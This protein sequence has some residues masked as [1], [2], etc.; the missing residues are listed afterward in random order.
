MYAARM[1]S[2]V[3]ENEGTPEEKFGHKDP[4]SIY[5]TVFS[6]SSIRTK[7]YKF[8]HNKYQHILVPRDY[9]LVH[10]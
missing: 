5:Y 6:Y 1:K 8:K 9:K 3:G 10:N 7:V 4:Q 2:K